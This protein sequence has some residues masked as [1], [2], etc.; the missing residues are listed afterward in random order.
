MVWN[1]MLNT[2]NLVRATLVNKLIQKVRLKEATRLGKEA[3][4]HHALFASEFKSTIKI[5][6]SAK[7]KELVCFLSRHFRFQY[8]MIAQVNDSAKYRVPDLKVFYQFPNISIITKIYQSKNVID[9]CNVLD[10]VLLGAFNYHYR[11][12]TR[13]VLQLEYHYII[14]PEDTE[15]ILRIREISDSKSIKRKD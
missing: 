5:I 11:I 1:E 6:E 8:N 3:Q 4:A 7:D 9:K 2:R 13:L 12:V 14:N 15:F 10:Q